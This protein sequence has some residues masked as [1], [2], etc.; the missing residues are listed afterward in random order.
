MRVRENFS[1]V[2]KML[3]KICSYLRELGIFGPKDLFLPPLCFKKKATGLFV[4][5]LGLTMMMTKTIN[6]IAWIKT[7]THTK[8]QTCTVSIL[9]ERFISTP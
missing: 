3:P 4:M 8:I 5:I 6:F 9:L 1:P 7:V 2:W